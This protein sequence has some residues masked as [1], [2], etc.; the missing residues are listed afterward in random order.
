MKRWGFFR[1]ASEMFV[2]FSGTVPSLSELVCS[3][4]RSEK[5]IFGIHTVFPRNF[6]GF[7]HYNRDGVNVSRIEFSRN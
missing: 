5:N 1:A 6:R 3:P 7:L 4:R 2:R